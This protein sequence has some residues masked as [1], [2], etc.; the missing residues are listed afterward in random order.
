[1]MDK[2]KQKKSVEIIDYSEL[3]KEDW[4]GMRVAFEEGYL[5]DF[6]LSMRIL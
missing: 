6:G 5:K 3:F 4:R 2:D 1:M